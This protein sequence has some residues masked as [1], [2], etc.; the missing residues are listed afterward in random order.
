[1]LKYIKSI[2][3]N[4][5]GKN[6]EIYQKPLNII[7]IILVIGFDIFLFYQILSGYNYQ[8]DFVVSVSEKYSCIN[9]FNDNN[10]LSSI[11]YYTTNDQFLKYDNNGNEVRKNF[12]SPVCSLVYEKISNIKNSK[13]FIDFILKKNDL[14][15]NIDDFN[16]KKTDYEY[17]YNDF[18]KES[19]AGITNE[20]E[21]ISDI[22]RE[23]ARKDYNDIKNKITSL[24]TREK[25]LIN[26]FKQNNNYL[27]LVNYL[28]S[29]KKEFQKKYDKEAFYYPVKI[30]FFQAILLLPLFL[31]SLFL[32]KVFVKRQNK[33]FTILFSNLTFIT[34]L[35]VFV[36]FLKFVYFIIPKKFLAGFIALLKSM[37]LGFLWN[38]I[39]ILLGIGLFGFIIY[40]SQKG[41]EKLSLIRQEQ[42]KQLILQNL[43]KVQLER[44][45]KGLCLSCNSKLLKDSRYCQTCGDDQYYECKNCENLIPKIFNY[46]NKCGTNHN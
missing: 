41:S 7:S 19:Q 27:D 45:E 1:M 12:D 3:S 36:L 38:Y 18:L 44:F 5:F 40:L 10:L 11:E 34:G 26:S 14:Q 30:A 39:L 6:K 2:F 37:N 43:K 4:M 46:C 24:E 31:L 17:Q 8:K 20:N 28:D 22:K 29:N 23:D 42:Q 13:E 33:I 35:F 25:E 15:K 9:Y 21:R 16:Y 32:Y